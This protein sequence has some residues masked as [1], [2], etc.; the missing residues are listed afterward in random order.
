VNHGFEHLRGGNDFF[1]R[2]VALLYQRFLN[3]REF[4]ERNFHAHVAARDHDAV[5]E[6]QYFFGVRHALTVLYLGNELNFLAAELSDEVSRLSYVVGGAHERQRDIV[7]VLFHREFD[8]AAIGF[9]QIRHID[10]DPGEVY[11]LSVGKFTAVHDRGDYVLAHYF[12]DFEFDHA[13]VK[14]NLVARFQH[15]RKRRIGDGNLRLVARNFSRGERKSRALAERDFAV[16]E[17]FNADF[18][19]FRVH[20]YGYRHAQFR[21]DAAHEFDTAKVFGVVAVRH[22]QSSHVQSR[23]H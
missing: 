14:Q 10:V 22:I 18:R 11:A 6:F 7:R 20:K 9:G 17:S 8:V 12:V 1:A 15:R 2:A 13:V 3:V 4:L 5:A 23:F 16:Y 21:A 19:T